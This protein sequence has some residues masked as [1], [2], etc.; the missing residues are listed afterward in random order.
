MKREADIFIRLNSIIETL[1]ERERLAEK[2]RM[3]SQDSRSSY[4]HGILEQVQETIGELN[5]F[6]YELDNYFKVNKK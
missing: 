6:K 3:L 5:K 1:E 4:W 2:K